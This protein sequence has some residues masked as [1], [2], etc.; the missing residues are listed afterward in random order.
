VL[1]F[2]PDAARDF[3]YRRKKSG[4][5]VSKMRFLSAQWLAYLEDGR[6]I[7]TARRANASAATLAESLSAIRDIEIAYPVEAN[8]VFAWVPDPIVA[9]LRAGG[10]K[11]Y[12]WRPSDGGR[13]L[14]RLV[15][16]FATR[17]EDIHGFARIAASG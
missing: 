5:L 12:D 2:D 9:R 13:T 14:I 15:C 10:A 17:E 11:F 6:W 1:F 7:D 8:A 16:S 3:E 4:H